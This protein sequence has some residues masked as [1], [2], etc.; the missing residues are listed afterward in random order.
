M[1]P[2]ITLLYRLFAF[3]LLS[4]AMI[5]QERHAP[6]DLS[7]VATAGWLQFAHDGQ[8]SALSGTPADPLSQIQWHTP[9]DLAPQYT[10]YNGN[11]VLLIHYG[12]P[13]V[14]RSNTVIVPVK[15]GAAGGFRVDALAGADGSL[16]WSATTDYI[17]PPVQQYVSTPVFG[18]ALT[19]TRVYFPG[20]GGTV[21]FRDDPDVAGGTSGQLVFYGLSNYQANPAAYDAS[22]IINTPLTMD[23]QGDLFFGFIVQGT[24]PV[25][26]QSGIA[27]IDATGE[28]SWASATSTSGDPSMTE[29][30]LNSAPALSPDQ[31]VVYV[32]ASNGASGYLVALNA[33]TLAPMARATLLD[34]KSGEPAELDDDSSASPTIGPDGDVYYGVLENP[35]GENNDRGWLLHFDATLSVVKAPGAFGWDD[36]ASIVPSSLVPSYQGKSTYLVMTKYNNY[37]GVGT[38]DGMNRIAILDP[39]GTETDAVTGETVMKEVLTILGPTP[40]PAGG[41]KEW[42]IN[43]TAVDMGGGA[44]LA[45]SEDGKLYRWDLKT[46]TFSESIVLTTGLG[47]A[48]TPTLI[49]SDGMVYAINNATL[50]AVGSNPIRP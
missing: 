42:C 19:A 34:P 22:V 29:V 37:I 30:A 26:L 43:S 3:L 17:L 20:A 7:G 44:I 18:P 15:T 33:Q 9:M 46:N 47:E 31:T 14:T 27:R 5:A 11:E 8:H 16:K 4:A 24:T 49:G 36:T 40:D 35:F 38:G 39:N 1:Q 45:N 50:F 21:Y 2:G 23:Q 32:V 10:T 25:P 6:V 48:Y 28:G 12:S 41:V 13:L